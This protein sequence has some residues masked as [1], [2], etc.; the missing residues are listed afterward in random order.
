MAMGATAANTT[1][2]AMNGDMVAAAGIGMDLYLEVVLNQQQTNKLTHFTQRNGKLWASDA[3]LRDLGFVLPTGTPDPVRVDSLPGVTVDYDSSRQSVSIMAPLKLLDFKTTLLNAPENAVPKATVSPGLLLNYDLYG[4]AGEQ[5]ADSLSAFTELRAFGSVGI[6]DNTSLSQVYRASDGDWQSQSVRLDTN[7]RRSWPDSML[8]LTVGDTVTG[9]L[10]WTRPTRIAGLQ[11]GRNFSLQPYRITTPV[12]AFFGQATL[13]SAVDLYVNGIKQYTGQ[14]PPGPYQ[15]S[16]V[17]TI[18]GSGTAQVVLTDAFGRST[19]VAFPF[20][21]TNQLLRKGLLD[22]SAEL[23]VVRENYGLTSF[24]YGHDPVASGTLRYGVNDSLTLQGHAEAGTGVIN[25]GAGGAWLIG[26]E[27]VLNG[28]LARS[29]GSAGSGTQV[30]IGYNWQK[31]PFNISLDSLRTYGSYRDI[32]SGYGTPPPD[33][34]ERALVGFTTPHTGSFSVSYLRL[35]YPGQ[36]DSRYASAFWSRSFGRNALVSFSVNQDLN[37]HSDRSVFFGL[38]LFLNGN[39]SVSTAA[40]HDQSGTTFTLDAN[41]PVPAN[42]GFGWRVQARQGDDSDGGLAEIGYR[43]RYND[44]T[45]GVNAFG[46]SRYAYGDASGSLTFM[47]GHLFAARRIDDA[48][49]VVSTDGV[50]NVPIKLENRVIGH[51][52]SDGM[53]LVTPLN[54]WQR[55]QLAIDPMQLPA[56]VRIGHVKTIATPMD[57]AGTLV[58]FGI[59]PMRAASIVLVDTAGKPLPLGSHVHIAGQP[60][61]GAIVGYDGAVYLDTL[62]AH[63]TLDVDTPAGLCHASFDYHK[64]GNTI[65]EI[66][67][68]ACRT[69]EKR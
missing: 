17:P 40:Q 23:G 67:P 59:T 6:F 2:L 52:D 49:A 36:D 63:N 19:T 51:T 7:W 28:S 43:N 4:T 44:L 65:P 30:G 37:N 32:A 62:E 56:D 9:A 25:A 66:G 34:S 20:Y 61:H 46:S 50:P 41:R 3:A 1:T 38:T 15:L 16:S 45:A 48:F 24:D 12:P 53:L 33:I 60:D 69:G 42:N 57:H 26:Q 54:A 29:A 18:T 22:G 58:K 47:D 64:Q 31:G 5:N 55:N 35:R 10:P 8:T 21:T 14:V 13:P 11:L 27:G 39:L 68:L